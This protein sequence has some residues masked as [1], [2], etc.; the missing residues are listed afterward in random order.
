MRTYYSGI[1][2]KQQKEAAKAFS[3]EKMK[4]KKLKPPL[5]VLLMA[6]NDEVMLAII[7]GEK[8]ITVR[9]GH[10]DF[11]EGRAVIIGCHKVGWAVMADVTEVKH[12]TLDE[13][14]EEEYQ[15]DGFK[16]KKELLEG[17]RIF[18]PNIN[19]DSPVTVVKWD[20][21][22]GWLVEHREE[23]RKQIKDSK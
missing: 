2:R 9:N 5:P 3:R 14:T 23:I 7:F 11:R 1:T 17:L 19:W 12:C 16:T 22:Q 13:V 21:V 20:N 18:F 8:K 4:E 15:A 6:P 10:Y